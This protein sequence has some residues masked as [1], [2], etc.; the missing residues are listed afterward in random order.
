MRKIALAIVS[1]VLAVCMAVGLVACGEGGN[2]T[3]TLS[4]TTLTMTVGDTETL[5]ATTSD[6]SNVTWTS[7]DESVA[8]VNSRGRVTAMG[9]GV[10]TITA[11]SGEATAT[12][13]VTVK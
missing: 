10:A 13:K 6:D 2:V 1:V 7:S 5:E 9:A 8:E 11:T 12:C 3:I 4:E